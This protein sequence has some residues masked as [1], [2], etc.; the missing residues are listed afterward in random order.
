MNKLVTKKILDIYYKYDEDLSLLN[1]PW[2]KKKDRETVS[3]EQAKVLGM[4]ID[5][6]EFLKIEGISSDLRKKTYIEMLELEDYIERDVIIILKDR[7]NSK[8]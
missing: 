8:I 6:M 3:F 7:I 4:Y 2:A 5:K 1:E